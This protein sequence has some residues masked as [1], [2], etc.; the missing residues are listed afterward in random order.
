MS[1]EKSAYFYLILTILL[2]SSTPALA[3]IALGELTNYQLLFYTSLFGVISLLLVNYFQGKLS[4]LR[5][6]SKSDF[7]KMSLMGF[8]GIYLYYIAITLQG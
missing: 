2:W 5:K 1:N 8:L 3:K 6:Y 4:N 7:I